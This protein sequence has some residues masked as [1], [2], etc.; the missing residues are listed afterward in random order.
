MFEARRQIK[1]AVLGSG[2]V[3]LGLTPSTETE[4]RRILA[5]LWQG[6]TTILRTTALSLLAAFLFIVLVPHQYTAVT[7]ILIDPTDLHAVGNVLTPSNQMSDAA[8]LQVESQ[9]RVLASDNVLRRVIATEG[10]DRD[11]VEKR[12]NLI[13]A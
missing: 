10:L 6:K 5:A 8:V 12:S 13:S 2:D 11:H 4:A 3:A 7:Q 9:V 1:S